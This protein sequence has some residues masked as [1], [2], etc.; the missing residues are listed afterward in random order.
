MTHIA[1]TKPTQRRLDRRLLSAARPA[2]HLLIVNMALQTALGA[3]VIAQALLL[4]RTIARVFHGG[5]ALAAVSDLLLVLA[6][7]ITVRAL[8]TFGGAWTAAQ[9][10][11]R[12]RESL[13]RQFIA[14]VRALGPAFTRAERSGELAL[15]AAEGIEKLDAYYREYLP[16]VF[17]AIVI[18][19]LILAAVLP[20]DALTF[21]ILLIT[22]PLIPL[23]MALIGMAAG[24]LARRQFL[25]MRHLGAHFL[26]V[27]Q[28]LTTLKLFN[29]S[30][31][32]AETIA[33]ITG[34]FRD[35]TLR[36]LRVAFLSAFTLEMLATLSVAIVAVEI[37][38]RLM[39]GGMIFEQAL[40]LLV[41]APEFYL[42]L[43]ALGARFHIATESKAA[44]ERIFA[45]LDTPLPPRPFA[46]APPPA[47]IDLRFEQVTFAYADG[48]R[49]A[50]NS[51]TFT[52]APGERVALV[53]A[54]G[55]GK[56][57]V[58][59]LLL[60]FV[61]PGAGRITV[62][63]VDLTTIDPDAWRAQIGWVSQSPYLFNRSAAD[64]IRM[65]RP[66]ASDAE[67]EAAARAVGAH[68]FISGLPEGYATRCGER[69]LRLSGGQAQRIALARAFLRD[70]PLLIL[71]EPT[72]QLDPE[73][74]RQIGAALDVLARGRTTLV[75]AHRLNTVIAADRILVLDQGRL[76]AQGTHDE[77]LGTSAH[78]RQLAE[79]Y[80]VGQ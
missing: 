60:R 63:G 25:E 28:G 77:L 22:A 35:A 45:V 8:L 57:T 59:N 34:Q 56:T 1:E 64:N 62:D 51:V 53:G 71:D 80:G 75:I 5:A 79:L 10:S 65:G 3:A 11:I 19:L 54:S 66:D 78:Y 55:G 74:E 16:G 46:F 49:P 20:L 30:A 69:G 13:R 38:I 70:A 31:A 50:L 6:L 48:A 24:A 39:N 68:D 21:V 41:I 26:D 43:R 67:V 17:V 7:V 44:A 73:S 9:V 12:T 36:V 15:T 52:I 33:R 32:Q 61:T 23:F 18:P 76:V 27:M 47:R 4:S 2:R 14:H 58:A 29:R 42:P 37:A 72:S 40:F